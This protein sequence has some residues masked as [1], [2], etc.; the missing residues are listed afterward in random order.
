MYNSWA[1]INL[2]AIAYNMSQI[3]KKIGP[4][5]KVLVP[6]KANGYGHG[7][8]D[9]SNIVLKNGAEMLG[10]AT[11]PE[12]ITLRKS[13]IKS[14]ILMMAPLFSSDAFNIIKFKIE[15][16]VCDLELS[17]ALNL[18]AK[19]QNR[20]IDVHIKVDTG[21]GR[22]G[23]LPLDTVNLA[24]EIKGLK[25]INLKGIF[26][27]FPSADCDSSFTKR[28]IAEFKILCN[29]LEKCGVHI[30]IKHTAN[31][32][33]VLLYPESYFDMVRPGLI[34]YGLYS[35]KVF[36]KKI[37]LKPALSW[38]TRVVFLKEVLSG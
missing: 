23:V 35:D 10:V 11:L 22:I 34:T 17:K 36:H 38:K 15:Q 6:V 30:P 9:V 26:T 27:H 8:I 29:K 28:Q 14:S 13:G 33:A 3:R 4:K 31:S 21:M 37:K 7:I 16:T 12:A 32:A 5:V 19:K 18:E 2:D 25:Y 24:L 20:K 1:E